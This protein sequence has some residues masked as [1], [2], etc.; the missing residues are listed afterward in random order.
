MNTD[1]E[2]KFD[3]TFLEN[4]ESIK[5]ARR[6]EEMTQE[7]R[8]AASKLIQVPEGLYYVNPA[9]KELDPFSPDVTEEQREAIRLECR[10]NWSYWYHRFLKL[11]DVEIS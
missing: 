1:S 6:Y 4:D 10:H 7:Q 11:A 8:A 5:L 2:F 9:L 3:A